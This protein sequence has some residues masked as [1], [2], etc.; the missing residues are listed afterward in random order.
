MHHLCV[1]KF[2]GCWGRRRDYGWSR[3][4]QGASDGGAAHHGLLLEFDADTAAHGVSERLLG[5]VGEV[6]VV[7]DT[8]NEEQI[9]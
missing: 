9:G 6:V 1:N 2:A 7:L 3:A 8:V 5:L 4:R